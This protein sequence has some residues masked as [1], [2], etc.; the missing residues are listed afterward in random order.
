VDRD[1]LRRVLW[2]ASL[3]L[4][5]AAGTWFLISGGAEWG[6]GAAP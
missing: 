4:A 2:V 1:R 6:P 5:L 3:I